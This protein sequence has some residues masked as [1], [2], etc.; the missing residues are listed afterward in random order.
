MRK[1]RVWC[2]V[3]GQGHDEDCDWV[4]VE[5]NNEDEA[6]QKARAKFTCE[7]DVEDIVEMFDTDLNNKSIFVE[8]SDGYTYGVPVMTIAHHH[9]SRRAKSFDNDIGLAMI[10]STIPLFE[11]DEYEIEDY[12]KNNMDWSD[13]EKDA[14]KLER[15]DK[16]KPDYQDEWI[17]NEFIIK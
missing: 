5:A 16:P 13:V 12:A 15:K 2:D 17:N 7:I 11:E 8:M 9:A 10:N 14:I 1:F 6:E 4:T 3:G